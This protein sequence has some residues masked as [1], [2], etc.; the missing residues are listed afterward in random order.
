MTDLEFWTKYIQLGLPIE[1]TEYDMLTCHGDFNCGDCPLI[2]ECSYYTISKL[3]NYR[4]LLQQY[5][6]ALL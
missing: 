4:P 1:I 6:E 3:S 5:P 2:K